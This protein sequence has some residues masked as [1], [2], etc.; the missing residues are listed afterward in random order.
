MEKT[1]RT[2]L[3]YWIREKRQYENL[4]NELVFEGWELCTHEEFKRHDGTVFKGCYT[5]LRP[6]G[7]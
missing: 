4:K 7:K 5:L 1:V 6:V 3:W 2:E